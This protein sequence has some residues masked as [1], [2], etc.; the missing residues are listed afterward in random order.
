MTLCEKDSKVPRGHS[1]VIFLDSTQDAC[2]PGTT[3][4]VNKL[5]LRSQEALDEAE[6]VAVPLRSME[7]EQETIRE[8]FTFSFYCSLHERLFGQISI[9]GRARSARWIS[10]RKGRAFVP[11]AG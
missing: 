2:Y 11:R 4:L 8:P 1:R 7:L 6:K 9:Q 3:V 10:R 5:G